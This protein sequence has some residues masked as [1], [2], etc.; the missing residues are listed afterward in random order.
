MHP[1]SVDKKEL[2]NLLQDLVR[3]PSVNPPG[4]EGL[5]AN[6]LVDWGQ[7]QG[8]EVASDDVLP[9]R[10]NVYITL[11]GSENNPR[12]LFNTHM[13]VVPEGSGWSREPF[14]GEIVD[15]RL[16][17]R[18]SADTKGSLAAML[19][20]AKALMDGR[21]PIK[22]SLTITAV[23][24]EEDAGKGTLH[25]LAQGLKADFAVVGEPTELK[26][27]IAAKGSST[28]RIRTQGKA[29]HSSVP[30]EGI[31][32]IYKMRRIIERLEDYS[33]ELKSRSHPILGHPTVSVDIIEG[34]SSPWIVPES[35]QITIDRRTLP[36]EDQGAIQE[37]LENLLEKIRQENS[38]VDCALKVHQTAPA[39]EIDGK[40]RIVRIA[41]EET[42]AVIGHDAGPSGLSGTTDA[43][44][45][46]NQSQIPTI[47][48]GP[49]SLSQAHQADEYVS[50]SQAYIAS[51]I[52]SRIAM[53]ALQ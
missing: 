51:T 37:E 48:F 29:A 32:A 19:L 30:D 3:I 42:S 7:S 6:Y 21:I 47:V 28:F 18:G 49:G 34:G 16:Y 43:R 52:L 1:A 13:D 15:D 46:I 12:L 33:N 44:F 25:S 4:N 8:F 39:A 45:L 24:D 31:N 23:S 5:L 38:E 11:N 17:G 9:G 53:K 27:V 50:I 35:C 36:G 14:G 41:L 40:A 22:G 20:A 26:V 10:P 2:I